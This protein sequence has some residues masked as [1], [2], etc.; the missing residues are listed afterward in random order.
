M[1]S[2]GPR[3]LILEEGIFLLEDPEIGRRVHEFD[4]NKFPFQTE[5]CLDFIEKNILNDTRIRET[6]KFCVDRPGL[7]FLKAL[8]PNPYHVFCFNSTTGSKEGIDQTSSKKDDANL[9]V[10]QL[11]SP[12][13][14][15]VYYKASHQYPLKVKPASIGLLEVQKE[16]LEKGHIERLEVTMKDGGL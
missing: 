7:G 4:E 16:S 11:L 10:V 12:G 5:E 8:G 13:S 14:E 6:V 1:A 2:E 9:L 3:N 15:M